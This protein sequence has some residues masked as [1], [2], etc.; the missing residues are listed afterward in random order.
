MHDDDD[1]WNSLGDEDRSR[2][3]RMTTET[4]QVMSAGLAHIFRGD[5]DSANQVFAQL[6]SRPADQAMNAHAFA[7][8]V[9]EYCARKMGQDPIDLLEE[10]A[11]R[12][13]LLLESFNEE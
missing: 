4:V 1:L 9:V 3:N 5:V 12:A 8:T 11:R 6:S 7:V 2:A 10:I 13:A